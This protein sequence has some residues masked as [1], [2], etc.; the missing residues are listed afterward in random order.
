M[1][2]TLPPLP[3]NSERER[4][5]VLPVELDRLRA[6]RWA[7][8]STFYGAD[9]HGRPWQIAKGEEVRPLAL[10]ER[11]HLT[12]EALRPLTKLHDTFDYKDEMKP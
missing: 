12:S 11:W 2:D 1:G 5:G 8:G 4:A 7:A 9:S 6:A 10:S 3:G